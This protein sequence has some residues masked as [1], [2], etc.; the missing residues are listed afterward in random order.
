MKYFTSNAEDLAFQATNCFKCKKYSR[1]KP[2]C[3]IDEQLT[4]ACFGNPK[5]D[6]PF[7]KVKWDDQKGWYCEDIEESEDQ[8]GTD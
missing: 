2:F 1:E 8:N 7:D 4:V 5:E 3:P 6:F